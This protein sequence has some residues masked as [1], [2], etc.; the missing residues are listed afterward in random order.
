MLARDLAKRYHK[1]AIAGSDAHKVKYIGTAYTDIDYTIKGNNDFI[2][3]VRLKK[4]AGCR[5]RD[6]VYS[7]PKVV[8][9]ILPVSLAWKVY[10]YGLGFLKAYSRKVNLKNL[11]ELWEKFKHEALPESKADLY[12]NGHPH[13][14]SK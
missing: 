10:N 13:H 3:A 11:K 6:E 7:E 14:A 9:K 1:P 5:C 2:N 4:I 8:T 12:R